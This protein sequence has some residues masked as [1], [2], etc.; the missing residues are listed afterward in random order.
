MANVGIKHREHITLN[1]YI[2]AQK[3]LPWSWYITLL[4][5]MKVNF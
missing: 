4:E 5:T 1:M 2:S 3:I